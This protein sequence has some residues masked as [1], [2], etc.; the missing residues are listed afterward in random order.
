MVV[1]SGKYNWTNAGAYDGDKRKPITQDRELACAYD[2][3]WKRLWATVPL[4][5]AC[6]GG[7]VQLP[8]LVRH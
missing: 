4:K 2:V 8:A 1:W 5:R 6:G 7:E 3:Q